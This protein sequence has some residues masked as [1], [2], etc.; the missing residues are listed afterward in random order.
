[1]TQNNFQISSRVQ[2]VL[3]QHFETLP[4]NFS[5]NSN[6]SSRF[7][8][9]VATVSQVCRAAIIRPALETSDPDASNGGPNVGVWL[10]VA[11]LTTFEK[12]E[13]TKENVFLS[14][15]LLISNS[16]SG[17]PWHFIRHEIGRI[18]SDFDVWH[19]IRCAIRCARHRAFQRTSNQR[20]ATLLKVCEAF[21]LEIGAK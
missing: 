1:M 17:Q 16:I 12:A 9:W 21:F 18:G 20:D 6:I 10:F 15:F 4:T 8:K 14:T 11:D 13:F 19:T 5:Q 3:R 7:Q 2:S